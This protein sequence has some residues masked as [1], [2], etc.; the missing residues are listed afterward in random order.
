MA[1][2]KLISRLKTAF[3]G[4]TLALEQFYLLRTMSKSSETYQNKVT[5]SLVAVL[6]LGH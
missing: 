2:K 5:S 4:E 1:A 6:R 3:S